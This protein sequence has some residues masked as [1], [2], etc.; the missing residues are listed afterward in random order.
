MVSCLKMLFLPLLSTFSPTLCL[1]DQ[2]AVAR[3]GNPV[4]VHS[5]PVFAVLG[6]MQCSLVPAASVSPGL[7]L[8]LWSSLSGRNSATMWLLP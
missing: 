7:A 3:I 2:L 4:R 1:I 8:N 5:Y 6:S